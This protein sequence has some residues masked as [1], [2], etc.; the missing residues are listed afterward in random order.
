MIGVRQAQAKF[1]M[2][3]DVLEYFKF[4]MLGEQGSSRLTYG[5]RAAES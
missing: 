3:V 5:A 2:T 1:A 4:G